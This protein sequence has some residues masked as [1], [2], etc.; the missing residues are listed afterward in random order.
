[1][2]PALALFL[3]MTSTMNPD[4]G[5]A[6]PDVKRAPS[7]RRAALLRILDRLAPEAETSLKRL[8][9]ERLRV[10]ELAPGWNCD[11]DAG[12]EMHRPSWM[13]GRIE[14]V[15]WLETLEDEH[16]HL[17]TTRQQYD[18]ALA[19]RR[20]R[21]AGAL[22]CAR[23]PDLRSGGAARGCATEVQRCGDGPFGGDEDGLY[24]LNLS[25][26]LELTSRHFPDRSDSF[27]PGFEGALGSVDQLACH[28]FALAG[29]RFRPSLVGT[30]MLKSWHFEPEPAMPDGIWLCGNRDEMAQRVVTLER[31]HNDYPSSVPEKW[32]KGTVDRLNACWTY[33]REYCK[34][35]YRIGTSF[36]LAYATNTCEVRRV[37]ANDVREDVQKGRRIGAWT[38]ADGLAHLEKAKRIEICEA[39]LNWGWEWTFQMPALPAACT[40]PPERSRTT[41]RETEI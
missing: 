17:P 27:D 10:L 5:P 30:E 32:I 21:I 25:E 7:D 34:S 3:A 37:T 9:A 13:Q 18:S 6:H 41:G 2:T 40:K 23:V 36:A 31:L 4:G 1:M 16:G 19:R 11:R 14:W 22:R 28:I 8:E 24:E 39:A 38:E 12:R 26:G 29:A 35:T 33:I 20:A 15:D